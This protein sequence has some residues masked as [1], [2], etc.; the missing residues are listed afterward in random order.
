[1]KPIKLVSVLLAAGGSRR[2]NGVKLSCRLNDGQSLLQRSI[3]QLQQGCRQFLAKQATGGL[4]PGIVSLPLTPSV[5]VPAA[6]VSPA[7]ALPVMASPVIASP[8]IVLTPLTVILGGHNECLAPLLPQ[9]TAYRLNPDWQQGLSSSI[10][11]AVKHA[12]EHEADA[13]LLALGDQV[14]LDA[15]DYAALLHCFLASV[16]P[17]RAKGGQTTAAFYR[18]SPGVPAIFLADDFA[19]LNQL[20]ADKGAKAILVERHN[21]QQLQLLP[22][23]RGAIDIDTQIELAQW[24]AGA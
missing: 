24:L 7:I 12:L 14:A 5:I 2:F 21:R 11:L 8:I 10:R 6:R 4:T 23:E 16:T 1:M 17:N 20:S 13:L 18:Q 22:L 9:G 3:E 19:A 15:S